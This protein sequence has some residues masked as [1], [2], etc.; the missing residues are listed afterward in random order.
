MEQILSEHISNSIV[1][2]TKKLD[3]DF[4]PKHLGKRLFHNFFANYHGID[5]KYQYLEQIGQIVAWASS[6]MQGRRCV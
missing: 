4:E 3:I 5:V 1:P 6:A 2:M